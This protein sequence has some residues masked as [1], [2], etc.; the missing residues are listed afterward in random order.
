MLNMYLT[1][2]LT[3]VGSHSSPLTFLFYRESKLTRLLKDSLG[4]RT[5]TCIIATISV[6]KMNQEEIVSTLD[7]AKRAKNI[8]NRPE[9]NQ[10]MNPRVLLREYEMTIE[11]L[12]ADLRVS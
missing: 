9:A 4:G 1:G 12:K 6:A 8:R 11:R 10:R 3:S 2:K 7:Y 5:K